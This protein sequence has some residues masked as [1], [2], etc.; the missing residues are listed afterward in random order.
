VVTTPG[1]AAVDTPVTGVRE[2]LL[3]PPTAGV[4]DAPRAPVSPNV[5][6]ATAAGDS[7][8][9]VAVPSADQLTATSIAGGTVS[10]A[11]AVTP[12]AAIERTL[13]RYQLAFS[14]LDV[15]A[16]RQVWPGV[17]GKA[18]AKAFDQLRREDL[19][20]QSCKVSVTGA[21]AVASCGGTTEYVPKIGTKSPRV[22]RR[23]WQIALHRN[24]E[25]WVIH[26]V[27]VS[28]Q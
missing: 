20:F 7:P 6:V 3:T 12:T 11:A 5:P 2:V 19:R 18:L 13:Q 22:E 8:P 24:A 21:T 26:R 4:A 17:D 9:V 15:D 28:E 25:Q 14:R 23:Q 1:Q 27:D 16:V 10:V